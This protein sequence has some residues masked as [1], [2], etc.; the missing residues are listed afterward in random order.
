MGAIEQDVFGLR[1]GWVDGDL[2]LADR[3]FRCE[4]PARP[5]C[6]LVLDRDLN[7]A[8]NLAKLADS[9]SDSLN[10]CGEDGSGQR[11]VALVK[12]S[13]MKQEPNAI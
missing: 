9:S 5:D 4:N 7:A 3:T 11:H 1:V 13:S 10:A 12:P 6:G 8:I 2:T